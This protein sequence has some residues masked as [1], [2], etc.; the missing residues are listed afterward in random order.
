MECYTLAS[1]SSGNA[2][3][4]RGGGAAVLLDA[5]ISARRIAQSL[6]RLGMTP[7]ELDA[8]LVTHE[9]TDHVGGLATLTKHC[10][11][12]V[13]A[14]RGTAR[15][16]RCEASRLRIF[17]A[18]DAFAVGGLEI[19]TFRT[20]HDAADS[21]DYRIDAPDGSFGALTDTGYVTE[22]A[23]RVLTGVELLLL[24]ANHDVGTLQSGPYPYHL[25]RRILGEHGHLSNDAAAEFA[26][27][28]A[29]HG[30]RDVLLAHLSAENNTPAMAEYAVA[31]RLQA[32]GC[33]VRLGVAPRDTISEAHT[34]CR[35]SLSFA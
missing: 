9:H 25:K 27:H 31:R 15:L 28:C 32:A 14:S 1:S 4:I 29:R 19:R 23:A 24:E 30:A 34:V 2:A 17:D 8:V 10:A 35:A 7:D 18:G 5:G 22:D 3:L 20:S 33:P 11:V 21:V 6:A 13:Y 16:L 12:P 26:L